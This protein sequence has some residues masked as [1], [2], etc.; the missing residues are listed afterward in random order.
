MSRSSLVAFGSR[1]IV[2]Q[3]QDLSRTSI[4]SRSDAS[5]ARSPIYTYIYMC[6]VRALGAVTNL[7]GHVIEKS[8]GVRS[9]CSAERLPLPF[10]SHQRPV[11]RP[12]VCVCTQSASI[13]KNDT[14][15]ELIETGRARGLAEI[16]PVFL[17]AQAHRVPRRE[18]P[19]HTCSCLIGELIDVTRAL[20]RVAYIPPPR[21]PPAC[22]LRRGVRNVRVYKAPW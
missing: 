11:V 1:A 16:D 22:G 3:Q 19:A 15:L 6:V 13:A 18:I 21:V 2:M 12:A 4:V 5:G 10:S 9:L 7:I 8:M 14:E 17:V 20:E